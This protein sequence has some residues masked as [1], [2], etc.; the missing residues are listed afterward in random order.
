M[1]SVIVDHGFQLSNAFS[2]NTKNILIR[3]DIDFNID[4]ALKMAKLESDLNFQTNYFFLSESPYY[5]LDS[6]DVRMKIKYIQ[7]FGHKIGLHYDD[8]I[9]KIKSFNNQ[10][11]KLQTSI[12]QEITVYSQHNPSINGFKSEKKHGI[13]RDIFH[14]NEEF[15][16]T[17]LSDSC[18]KPRNEFFEA[19][20][21]AK[22]IHLLVHPEFWI[23]ETS[24]LKDFE[25]AL[26]KEM[27]TEFHQQIRNHVRIMDRTLKRR[28]KLD[29]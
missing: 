29:K 2:K 12:E 9:K 26:K 22:Y 23:L 15:K 25:K 8:G 10:K 14:L 21:T 16:T 7:E 6:R 3:H 4:C 17:Y 13:V 27:S 20:E 28:S 1:L 19:F 18:M 24:T 5:N 11:N